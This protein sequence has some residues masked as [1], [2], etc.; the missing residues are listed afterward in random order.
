[1]RTQDAGFERQLHQTQ[2]RNTQ[3]IYMDHQTISIFKTVCAAGRASEGFNE[4]S[5]EH[6]KN[7]ANMGL[8]VVAYTPDLLA[9]RREYRPTEKGWSLYSEL[10]KE[11][12]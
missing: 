10:E 2:G 4:D 5:N 8:L 1:M 9:R 7:L 6:L 12:V 3:F 11:A